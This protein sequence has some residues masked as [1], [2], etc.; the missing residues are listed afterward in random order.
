MD[1][2][3]F[4]IVGSG[5][6][7]ATYV[8]AI[9]AMSDPVVTVAAV[10]SRSGRRVP[11]LSEGVPVYDSLS[12]I[13]VPFDGVILATPNGLHHVGAIEAAKLGK[14]VLTE[15]CLDITVPAMD[16][17]LAA[18]REAGLKLGVTFQRRVSPDNIVIKSVLNSGTLGRILAADLSVK[19]YRDEAYYD[20]ADYRG[21]KAIDGGGPFIQQAAHNVDIFCW[22]FGM[23]VRVTSMLGTF[24]HEI[25]GEDHGVALLRYADGMIGTVTA[26]TCCIPGFPASL[27]IHGSKG[28]VTMVNDE[29]TDWQV[30]GV[31]NP[32]RAGTFSVHSGAGSAA[33]TDTAG[34]EAII[35]DFVTAVREDRDPLVTGESA[36]MATELILEIYA[37]NIPV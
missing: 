25:E 7:S 36:R 22:L 17:M 15:K 37:S 29:I 8:K 26:S 9:E 33:V 4:A 13:D 34:H 10:V 1:A 6:I 19:F 28:C 32:S 20:S 35:A 14:H 16:A 27:S 18:C 31:D 5:G 2:F 11:G 23:P 12:A 3:R 24:M 30:P 21:N